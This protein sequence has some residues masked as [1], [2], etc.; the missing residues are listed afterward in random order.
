MNG[1]AQQTFNLGNIS[2]IKYFFAVAF[3]LGLLFAFISQ[4]EQQNQNLLMTFIQWQLQTGIP[5]ALLISSHMLMHRMTQFEK[6][7]PW[8]Q[9]FIS[10]LLGVVLF[11]P[12]A[13][14]LD[15][16]F[17]QNVYSTQHWSVQLFDELSGVGPPVIIS[18]LAMNA[19]WI[20][21]YRIKQ[22]DE[23]YAGNKEHAIPFS[24]QLKKQ[25]NSVP[26]FQ[27]LPTQIGTEVVFIKAE[28]HYIEVK[29]TIGKSLILYNLRDAMRE[30]NEY[31]G[32]QTHRSYWVNLQH[33]KQ[34]KKQGRQ[35]VL[36]MQDGDEVPVSRTRLNA[37]SDACNSWLKK[38]H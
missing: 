31:P 5:I 15:Y 20:L 8:L 30:L 2:P 11:A 32:I 12:L 27:L 10:G 7:N 26:F 38:L 1:S 22:V 18:W 16:Y 36:I 37:V 21:G 23:P 28:L 14:L 19:P 29:T 34:F 33:L 24:P 4:G 25:S 9:L 3:V 6:L 17:G 35:G 13:L